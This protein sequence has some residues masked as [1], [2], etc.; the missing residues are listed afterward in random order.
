MKVK[1]EIDDSL[2]EDE[3]VIHTKEYTE[4]LKQLISNFKSNPSIQFFKQDTEYYLDLDAILFF[5]S[6]NG[7]VYAHTANDMFSTTQ[8]LYELE[9]I[10]PNSWFL[11][12]SKSTI[13]NIQKIYSLS[14]SVSSHL[15]T[16]QNSHKQVYVSRMYYKVLKERRN[17]L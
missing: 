3:I 7:R 17:H 4:E 13:V 1:L 9:N 2:K 15:I 14:H 6:D 8:K 5:E 12:I 10:L 11:R 16:F